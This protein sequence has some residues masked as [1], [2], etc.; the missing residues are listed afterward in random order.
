MPT[1]WWDKWNAIIIMGG[2]RSK[3]FAIFIIAHSNHNRSSTHNVI[4]AITKCSYV[5]IGTYTYFGREWAGCTL[6]MRWNRHLTQWEPQNSAITL[7]EASYK[8][9][10][11]QR[12]SVTRIQ[13]KIGW[14]CSKGWACFNSCSCFVRNTLSYGPD[15]IFVGLLRSTDTGKLLCLLRVCKSSMQRGLETTLP[16]SIF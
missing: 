2:R 11:L 9:R 7:K 13:H 1:Y 3:S 5:W 10:D 16:P 15:I 8:T 6:E 12:C 4:L 14:Q